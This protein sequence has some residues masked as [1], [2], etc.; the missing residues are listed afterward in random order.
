M[1]SGGIKNLYVQ[2][3]IFL[4]HTDYLTGFFPDSFRTERNNVSFVRMSAGGPCRQEAGTQ[5]RKTEKTDP[6][7]GLAAAFI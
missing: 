1:S 2:K 3:G 5:G 6:P 4:L 7:P